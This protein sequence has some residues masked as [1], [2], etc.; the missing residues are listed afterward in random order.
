VL[1]TV[2]YSLYAVVLAGVVGGT[3]AWAHVDK[4]VTVRVDGD[5][6]SVHTTAADVGGAL[7]DA[8]VPVGEHDIVAPALDEGIHDGS[9]IV[10]KR[11]RLLLLDVDGRQRGV[12]VTAR[13]VAEALNQLGYSTADF[14]S[15]SR[16]T[17]LPLTPT[18][19]EVR[20][21]KTVSVVADGRTRMVTTTDESVAQVLAD[22]GLT[23]GASD[24]LSVPPASA[25]V[26][27]ENIVLQRI[28]RGT[29]V[30]YHPVP[31]SITKRS[32]PTAPAG[33][34]TIVTPGRAGIATLKY[35]V[36]YL[37][38]KLIGKT[39]VSRSITTPPVTQ[40]DKIGSMVAPVAPVAP[41]APVAVPV[42]AAAPAPP[43]LNVDPGSAQGIARQ[44]LAQRGMGDD[45]FSCLVTLWD[46]ESGWR[47][48]AQ[49]A[50]SGAYGIPQ[51]LPGSKMG[52]YGA[53]WPT[54]P[55]TQILWGLAYIQGRYGSPCQAWASWQV[56]GWY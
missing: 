8:K 5:S 24:R 25:P 22:L 21:P 45:Q 10:L 55:E 38:G 32:D 54:N 30:V 35:A 48:N 18:D 47:V 33:Q 13:T 36:V 17:R 41:I 19:I 52:A 4:T 2:K 53:D 39:L 49:N 56:Q 28:T 29:A 7:T 15:V 46:H 37:D 14:S 12:W 44:L 42:P 9:Q 34:T 31:F 40:V 11:G 50:G 20:T 26:D 23:V 1:R 16:A 43:V 51:A 3:V 6:R 27:R